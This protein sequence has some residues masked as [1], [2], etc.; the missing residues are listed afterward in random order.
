M[1]PSTQTRILGQAPLP[2]DWQQYRE[3]IHRLY[4]TEDLP[5]SDVV[6]TMKQ[7]HGFTAT[8]RQYKRRISEWHIDKNVK[9]D[10]MRA[11]ISIEAERQRQGKKSIF[12]VRDR[13]VGPK[14]IE[15]FARR[16]NIN[17]GVVEHYTIRNIPPDVRCL[18]PPDDGPQ[19][20]ERHFQQSSQEKLQHSA[21]CT[22]SPAKTGN[23]HV[24]GLDDEITASAAKRQSTN[25]EL[26]Q[27]DQKTSQPTCERPK[28]T[29]NESVSLSSGEYDLRKLPASPSNTGH[30]SST[31]VDLGAAQDVLDS[32][33]SRIT[34]LHEDWTKI[35]DLAERRRIQNRI[36]QRNYR[37]KLQRRLQDL[38]RRNSSPS[39]PSNVPVD[40]RNFSEATT[41]DEERLTL[42]SQETPA[43]LWSDIYDDQLLIRSRFISELLSS[44]HGRSTQPIDSDGKTYITGYPIVAECNNCKSQI[45][46]FTYYQ[47][48]ECSY[49][50]CSSCRRAKRA[51][52]L[53]PQSHAVEMITGG[54]RYVAV[55][56]EET[57]EQLRR[58]YAYSSSY[59]DILASFTKVT[60]CLKLMLEHRYG[61]TQGLL[62][63]AIPKD[64]DSIRLDRSIRLHAN[65]SNL[66]QE[67]TMQS[68]GTGVCTETDFD[69]RSSKSGTVS[70]HREKSSAL[71]VL[72]TVAIA[73]RETITPTRFH[74]TSQPNNQ[75]QGPSEQTQNGT[76][77]GPPEAV[78]SDDAWPKRVQHCNETTQYQQRVPRPNNS[79]PLVP[80]PLWEPSP[81]PQGLPLPSRSELTAE[82]GFA[83]PKK[84]LTYS[85]NGNVEVPE[86]F[87]HDIDY[88]P[89]DLSYFHPKSSAR[90]TP[91]AQIREQQEADWDASVL[92]TISD[93]YQDELYNLSMD[94][95]TPP[96]LSQQ[97]TTRKNI[98][99]PQKNSILKELLQAAQNGHVTA[100]SASSFV[101]EGSSQSATNSPAQLSSAA[102]IRQ[103][104]KA[105]SEQKAE[106]AALALAEHPSQRADNLPPRT[107]T[108]KE[109][110]LDFNELE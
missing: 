33:Q 31:I 75:E 49:S 82:S 35:S 5:L 18:T 98:L 107:I 97:Y 30:S 61:L 68:A 41:K 8:E 12:Y 104:Q 10:E 64:I 109:V 36:A 53:D 87:Q 89:T 28:V 86:P 76:L 25:V 92:R 85:L 14:K 79:D 62:D 71:E 44:A 1:A 108:P 48:S 24:R 103:Q 58:F 7:S 55:S 43:I 52:P 106:L 101:N 77:S 93:V 11:I 69:S 51:W 50:I 83:S 74:V 65:E 46:T 59:L 88:A 23:K 26:F 16:K 2:S 94:T 100:R 22:D 84:D 81:T 34:D 39:L 60:E 15:R 37:R 105:E 96:P 54:S 6:H 19:M 40:N 21:S 29:E 102:Q 90:M 32:Q 17:R 20:R 42:Q 99:S 47:C 72:S 45:S 56:V 73:E 57:W 80:T 67:H 78:A 70:P 91:A 9:E 13:E 63:Q 3:T 110:T 66:S 38:E 95:S 4:V 27:E